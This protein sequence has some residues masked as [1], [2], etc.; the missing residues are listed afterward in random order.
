VQFSA[1][2]EQ[3]PLLG[4]LFLDDKRGMAVGAYGAY[5]ETS[6]GGSKWTARKVLEDD[7]H[8]NAIVSVG[9]GRLLIVGEAGTLLRSDDAGATWKPGVSPYKGSFFGAVMAR[10][11][12]VLAFGLRGHVFR[13]ADAGGTWTEVKTGTDAALASATV[14]PDGAIAVAGNAGT[15]LVSRDNGKSFSAVP[16]GRRQAL[17][18]ALPSK[19]DSVLVL[20]EGGVSEVALGP[21]K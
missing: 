14:L 5:Y 9:K 12:S 1:P 16:T 4:V 11:E 19:G 15:L 10:D 6:D 18:R 2:K 17:A 20:G 13:S 3:R 8:L 21:V 7:K